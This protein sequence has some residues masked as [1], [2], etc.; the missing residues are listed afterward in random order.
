[1]RYMRLLALLLLSLTLFAQRDRRGRIDVEHYDI[2]VAVAPAQQSLTAKVKM[3]FVP[4]DD[5]LN[6]VQL[7]FNDALR[8]S[9][10]TTDATGNSVNFSRTS[11]FNHRLQFG[12]A[13]DKGKPV[14]VSFEYDG[15][16]DGREESPV[17]GIRFASIEPTG[18]TLLYP[19]RWF[20]VNEYTA[21]RYT[22][23]LNVNEPSE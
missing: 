12:A 19:S 3:R 21:D 11:D 5:R 4:L 10:V 23:N 20:P 1:M 13:L 16:F 18:A 14:T 8:V 15:R 7:D 17:Y 9:N 6:S 2:D 22:M